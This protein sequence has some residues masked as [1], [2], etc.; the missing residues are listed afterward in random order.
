MG[1]GSSVFQSQS[2]G[3]GI[4]GTDRATAIVVI[5]R[6]IRKIKIRPLFGPTTSKIGLIGYGLDL[7]AGIAGT[8]GESAPDNR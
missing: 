5:S 7:D 8:T 3:S 6:T 2:A 1:I 4:V